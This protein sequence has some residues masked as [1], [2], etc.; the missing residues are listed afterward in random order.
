MV[1]RMKEK[2]KEIILKLLPLKNRI[3]FESNPELSCNALPVYEEMVR[4]GIRDKY[5]IYWLVEDKNKYKDDTSGNKYLNYIETGLGKIKKKYILATSKALI[6][7]NRIQ[8]KR[9]D[10]Q[11]VINLMHGSPVK[12]TPGYYE[13]DTCDYVITESSYFNEAVSE[14][15]NVPVTKMV[16]L[17]FP[18]TD[19]LGISH[20]SRHK[21]DIPDD[22]KLIIWMPT[23]RKN[24]T[25]GFSYGPI[26]ELGV[27]LLV[28]IKQFE[29]INNELAKYGIILIIKLHPAEDTS[30]MKLLSNSN[31]MFISDE[32]LEEVGLTAYKLLA[33]SDALLTDY[34]SVYYDYLLVDKPI[35]LVTDNL[36]EF[37]EKIGFYYGDYKSFM[38]GM[39]I[40]TI[41]DLMSFVSDVGNGVDRDRDGRK[42]AIERYCQYKD[43]KSTD[44]VVD[45]IMRR[46][47][48][49]KK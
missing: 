9:K 26:K 15:L 18:R 46:I 6:F 1:M 17:G 7:T 34:S 41:N 23:F 37:T 21:L 25:S 32:D 33:D 31:I 24:K 13:N 49:T 35:G 47:G 2:I 29:E 42:W 44:R 5:E 22:K 4:R 16:S 28:T 20:N 40:E 3:V 45:F 27:P 39:Y 14:G 10:Q 8:E 12:K 30:G 19:I 48:E 43:F 36:E 11:L 38:K